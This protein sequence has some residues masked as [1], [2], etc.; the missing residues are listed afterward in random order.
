MVWRDIC[1]HKKGI[2]PIYYRIDNN[3]YKNKEDSSLGQRKEDINFALDELKSMWGDYKGWWISGALAISLLTDNYS[4]AH[5]NIDIAL[6]R[7]RSLL[8]ALV[9]KAGEHNLFLFR[10]LRSYKISKDDPI[11]YE[12]FWPVTKKSITKTV[13][14]YRRN[15]NLQFCKVDK[16]GNII[17]EDSLATRIKLYLHHFNEQGRL[18]SSEKN[19]GIH[20]INP[21]FLSNN[22]A[23]PAILSLNKYSKREI[24]L[25][26]VDINYL[27]LIKERMIAHWRWGKNQ[28]HQ[29]DLDKILSFLEKSQPCSQLPAK[30]LPFPRPSLSPA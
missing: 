19:L 27:K 11:K 25:Y 26:I 20:E 3:N 9:D 6:M 14:D 29:E 12:V 8:E 24:P 4:R 22:P 18:V 16:Y 15:A 10:K 30:I 5:S 17:P 21:D 1:D 23:S 2:A 28:K 13:L 7:N